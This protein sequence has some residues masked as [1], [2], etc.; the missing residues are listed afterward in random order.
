MGDMGGRVGD[1]AR[2]LEEESATLPS[3]FTVKAGI[4]NGGEGLPG[5]GE[6]LG[7]DR[8]CS[9][10]VLPDAE[11]VCNGVYGSEIIAQR[12]ALRI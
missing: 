10:N 1:P 3:V 4:L 6:G 5:A 11:S 7:F 12:P 9:Q 2:W 8:R